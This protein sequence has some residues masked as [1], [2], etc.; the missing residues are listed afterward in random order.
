MDLGGSGQE[1][2]HH[3]VV[4]VQGR[5][6]HHV[7]NGLHLLL[8]VLKLLIDHGAK[9]SDDLGLLGIGPHTHFRRLLALQAALRPR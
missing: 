3:R 6:G 2:L 8:K 9:Y 7:P 4:H 1:A 5:L